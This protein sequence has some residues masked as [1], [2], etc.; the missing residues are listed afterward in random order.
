MESIRKEFA[1]DQPTFKAIVDGFKSEYAMGL[2]TASASGLATMIPSYVTALPTGDEKG[3]YLALDLGGSTLRV[4]AVELRQAKR[5]NVKVT[6]LKRHIAPNDPLRTS[7]AVAFFDWIVD[8]IDELLTMISAAASSTSEPLSLGVCWSF[9]IDQTSISTGKILRM[10]KG[11]TIDGIEGLD[12][13]TLFQEAFE[14]KGLRVQVR[15]LLNDT[16]GTLVAHAYTNPSTRI[17]FIYGTGVNA[18]YPEKVSR[19]V[20]LQQQQKAH[21]Q[22]SQ[23]MMLV[24]TEIDIFGSED[25]LPLNRYDKMLDAQHSQPKFQL[26]EKM[27]SG[28]CMGELVRLAALDLIDKNLLFNGYRPQEFAIPMEFDTS[29]LSL[30]E[31]FMNETLEVRL[32]HFNPLFH[33]TEAY[34]PSEN[35]LR[36]LTDLCQ[37]VSNRAARLAA[38]AVASLIEQQQEDLLGPRTDQKPIVIGVNGS[39]YEKYPTM[40]DRIHQALT[41]WFGEEIG[42]RIQLEV[43]TDG[44][45]IGGALI[46]M[47]A[48]KEEKM[49]NDLGALSS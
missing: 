2:N 45:S 11:F 6:E 1:L 17:G 40:H 23:Q 3:T 19:I 15:A 39:T 35:D 10:G 25:Y 8:A 16:V 37:I 12:L 26:Y 27:M 20:K 30:I 21:T 18:A 33:F 47:L 49:M 32:Q 14:R 13:F 9:P 48:E 5:S 7:G 38:A 41:E 24:N 44:G 42:Q 34:V 29:V 28:G 4:C 22:P 31:S 46:A 43:A 36:L